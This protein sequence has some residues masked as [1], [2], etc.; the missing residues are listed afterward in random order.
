MDTRKLINFV[1]NFPAF[2]TWDK[3]EQVDYIA[4]FLQE[5]LGYESFTA[6]QIRTCIHLLA[7]SP[8]SRVS[9]YLSENTKGRV[10]KYVKSKKGYR[11]ER[12]H[13]FMVK[14]A[15]GDEVVKTKVSQQLLDLIP[16]VSDTIE[17]DFL[18]EAIKC[19]SVEAYRASV[20]LFWILTIYHLRNYI[21][22]GTKLTDFNIALAQNPYKKLGKISIY[23][24]FSD[25]P[26]FKFIELMRSANIISSDIRKILAEKL[27]IRNTAAHP[28]LVKLTGH[29][30]T[31][32]GLDLINNIILKY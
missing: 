22:Y 25:I 5:R 3:K 17:K 1:D 24:D 15:I 10:A 14:A 31:E 23:D 4:Y 13:C 19:Y 8:Y 32:F 12:S 29:K 7:L 2:A 18:E 9:A 28:A 11:L 21:F 20:V 27:D 16:S 26:D 6:T 30:A